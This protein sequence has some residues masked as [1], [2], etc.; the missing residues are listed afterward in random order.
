LRII[1]RKNA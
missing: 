1:L